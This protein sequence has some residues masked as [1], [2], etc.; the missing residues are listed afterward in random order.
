VLTALLVPI[1]FGT[2]WAAPTFKV[3]HA[4]AG[5]NDGANPQPFQMVFDPRGNLYGVTVNGG[6]TTDCSGYGCGTVFELGSPNGRWIERTLYSFTTGL[7]TTG[8]L[9]IGNNGA[10]Y[11]TTF[12]GGSTSCQCGE[13]YELTRNGQVWTETVLH[14]FGGIGDGAYLQP[15]LVRD[16]AGNLYGSTFSGGI[17]S[18]C[19]AGCGTVFQLSPNSDGTWTE[20]VI[21]AFPVPS[22]NGSG[23]IGEMAMDRAGNLY[24]TTNAGGAYDAGTV[25]KLTHSNGVWTERTIY[26][27]T[28]GGFG[29]SSPSPS[30][31]VADSLG[32]LYGTTQYGGDNFVGNVCKLSPTQGYW[33]YSVVHTFTGGNDGGFP[34]GGLALDQAGNLYGTTYYGGLFQYGAVYQ[35]SQ[36]S[37]GNWS[38]SVLHSFTNGID[39]LNPYG[40]T[41][42]ALGNVYGTTQFGGSYNYGIAYQIVP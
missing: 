6:S 15:G 4:F 17:S 21:Y 5:G 42:D 9:A 38:E 31:I 28:P 26:D 33:N 41:L 14:S 29:F 18:N 27:F 1:L 36:D 8:P 22:R 40:V 25:Y 30:G 11:G 7:Y 32:N 24:G 3:I 10:I 35:F 16:R 12:G 20:N 19:F 23:P 2:V 37:T 39:G 13:V 34:S